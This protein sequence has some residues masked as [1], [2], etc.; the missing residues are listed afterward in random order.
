[1]AFIIG[2]C[3]SGTDSTGFSLMYPLICST[4]LLLI[5]SELT[6]MDLLMV[7]IRLV[8]YFTLITPVPFGGMGSFGHEGTVQPQDALQLVMVSGGA[9]DGRSTL[10][11]VH[12]PDGVK[13][14][15]SWA[16]NDCTRLTDIR[17]P[18]GVTKIEGWAFC[19]CRGISHIDIPNSVG[20][21][22]DFA[23]GSCHSL[24][25][26]RIPNSVTT[27]KDG[28]LCECKQLQEIHFE[29]K[30]LK[31]V[32]WADEILE[33]V[34]KVKCTIFVPKGTKEKYREYPAFEGFKI[35]EE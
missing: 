8:S 6:V 16:F 7:P 26:I 4:T 31:S 24:S 9:F 17:I 35:V 34:D 33:G 25:G 14:I 5:A 23:F 11:D 1:M 29:R 12:I 3:C 28:F 15:G 21:I 32:K 27:I 13:E 19:G 10:I 18:D 22:G 20:T 30:G 2:L